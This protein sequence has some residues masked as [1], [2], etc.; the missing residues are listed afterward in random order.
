MNVETMVEAFKIKY[1]DADDAR[2]E[3]YR[4]AVLA[5]QANPPKPEVLEVMPVIVR[6]ASPPPIVA[7]VQD[8][9]NQRVN[10]YTPQFYQNFVATNPPPPTKPASDLR[11]ALKDIILSVHYL[12][13]SPA[14]QHRI[15]TEDLS[16]NELL[17]LIAHGK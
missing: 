9:A 17:Q 3:G 8:Y 7:V 15:R 1:P 2:V 11:E 14:L 6:D 5:E 13:L 4:N 16:E 12:R 10:T